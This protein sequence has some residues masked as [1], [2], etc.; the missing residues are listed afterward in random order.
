[1]KD[2][3]YEFH[4]ELKAYENMKVPLV[5]FMVPLLQKLMKALYIREK[6]GK[7]LK[8]STVRIPAKDGK[9]IRVLLYEPGATPANGACLIFI[10]GGG[11]VF[12]A[13]PHHF[14]LAR[15]LTQ[16]LG[17]K[18]VF[19]DYRLAPK[20]KYPTAPEDCYSVY[21]WLLKH[22]DELEIDPKRIAVCGDSA[23]GTLA[24][25]LCLMAKERG[26][27]MPKA[28]VLLYPSTDRRMITESV[29]KY[30]DTPMC[31]SKDMD[32][33]GKMYSGETEP[34]NIQYRSP[35]EAKDLTGLPD[36]YIEVAEYDCLHDEGVQY[37]QALS[38]AGAEVELHEIKGAMH[39]YDIAEKSDLVKSCIEK[40]VR[41]LEDK[42]I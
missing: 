10:H 13:A 22:A 6:S 39:G 21:Q 9:K 17:C 24:T 34:E 12:Q 1:M 32:R 33:Y 36:A 20:Y 26:V 37:G 15:K 18:T 16:Q 11:Y 3:K 25:A 5:P 14:G 30:T 28:Q 40:R 8:V 2:K 42:I 31:N 35:I 19:I 4:P 38:D 41:F 23:G 27:Q 7:D 29:K